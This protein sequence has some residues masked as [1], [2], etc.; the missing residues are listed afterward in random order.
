MAEY[1]VAVLCFKI[2]S[3]IAQ[4]KPFPTKGVASIPLN[5]KGAVTR[6]SIHGIVHP[7]SMSGKP[8]N[9]PYKNGVIRLVRPY[10]RLTLAEENLADYLRWTNNKRRFDFY[11]TDCW[12][13]HLLKIPPPVRSMVTLE[14]YRAKH[15]RSNLDQITPTTY[16]NAQ[17]GLKDIETLTEKSHISKDTSGYLYGT[18]LSLGAC[19]SIFEILSKESHPKSKIKILCGLFHESQFTEL[20]KPETL[21]EKT[22][23]FFTN[24]QI[25]FKEAGSV[26]GTVKDIVDWMK[27]N[28]SLFPVK[29]SVTRK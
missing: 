5:L 13:N 27:K 18:L 12:M 19:F 21:Y 4:I 16:P 17:K 26:P 10:F 25:E 3:A 6:V 28:P 20:L 15:V 14:F 23:A 22:T 9:A 29:P 11:Y 7:A 2:V 8:I 1:F 24:M